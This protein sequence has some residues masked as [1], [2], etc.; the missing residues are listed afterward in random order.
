MDNDA[1]V[2]ELA[3]KLIS[4]MR[5]A[6]FIWLL[7][8]NPWLS[9]REVPICQKPGSSFST[10]QHPFVACAMLGLIS[11]MRALL[12]NKLKPDVLLAAFDKSHPNVSVASMLLDQKDFPKEM[13]GERIDQIMTGDAAGFPV[14]KMILDY[15]VKVSAKKNPSFGDTLARIVLSGEHNA[16]GSVE[17]RHN[18]MTLISMLVKNGYDINTGDPLRYLAG[19]Y[20]NPSHRIA[21][22][23]KSLPSVDDSVVAIIRIFILSGATI[24]KDYDEILKS[25]NFSAEDTSRIISSSMKVTMSE[26]VSNAQ[27]KPDD[28]NNE[29]NGEKRERN[30]GREMAI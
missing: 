9:D 11:P 4:G 24:P 5:P 7:E 20:R 18:L 8:R 1:K 13:L 16:I 6:S 14:T 30:L 3:G 10:M 26:H 27:S 17:S 22:A 15:G 28:A 25:N 23:S 12:K 19:A 2:I 29:N 21:M